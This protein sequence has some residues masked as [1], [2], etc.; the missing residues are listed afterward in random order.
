[1]PPKNLNRRQALQLTAATLAT[2]LTRR[3]SAQFGPPAKPLNDPRLTFITTTESSP[4]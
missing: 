4:W 2:T 3:S 1:M